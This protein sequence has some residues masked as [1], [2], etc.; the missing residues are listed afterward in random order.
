ME[1]KEWQ[2]R[3][4]LPFPFE[5]IDLFSEVHQATSSGVQLQRIRETA[6]HFQTWFRKT[7]QVSAFYSYDL[8]T[9]P[10]PTRYGLWRAT[11]NPAPFLWFTNRMFLVQWKAHG[12]TWTLL[13]EPTD[14]ERAANTPYYA[15][16]I[17][18][19]GTYVSNRLLAKRHGTVESHLAALGLRP[20]DIDFITYDHLHT[21]DI[22]RWLGTTKPQADWEQNEPLSPYFPNA[23]LIVQR[24][25]WDL[26]QT[27]HPLQKIW[28]QPAT[29]R[30][31]PRERILL[32]DGDVLLG[33][34]AALIWTPGHT[35][36]NHSLVVNT[37]TGIWVSSENAISAE[38]LTPGDSSLPGLRNY[39]KTTGL[40]VV[41]N[42]NT[43]EYTAR[44]YNSLVLEKELADPVPTNSQIRQFFPSSEW[45]SHPLA[46]G[47]KPS[48]RHLRVALG[49]IEI[50]SDHT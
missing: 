26:L 49:K 9:L 23:K 43:L 44:Q 20:E 41:I 32:I 29:F 22:R 1:D 21:Q 13:S 24:K 10:Y 14:Y 16:L 19:Y 37:E 38:C 2:A 6:P 39:S 27:L 7:G 33:P 42:G 12:K 35:E 45:T 46:L 4:R 11:Q 18:K 25:E 30:D 50:P 8:I 5:P 15:N 31:I 47:L 3:N 34:G 28:Y 17:D 40:E 36:G 48:F